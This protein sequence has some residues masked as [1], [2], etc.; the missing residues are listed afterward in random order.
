MTGYFGLNRPTYTYDHEGTVIRFEC[1]SLNHSSLRKT[2]LRRK[3]QRQ[4]RRRNRRG[5]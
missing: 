5:K 4:A 2:K 3:A 1:I